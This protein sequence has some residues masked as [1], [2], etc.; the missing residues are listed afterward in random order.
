ME[1]TR[2]VRT[3]SRGQGPPGGAQALLMRNAVRRRVHDVWGEA[4]GTLRGICGRGRFW[5]VR[6]RLLI[7]FSGKVQL[8]P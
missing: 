2:I 5:K 4:G 7:E 8:A 1:L 3:D 6:G